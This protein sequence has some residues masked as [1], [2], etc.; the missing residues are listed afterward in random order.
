MRKKYRD[1]NI[2]NLETYNDIKNLVNF[3]NKNTLNETRVYI[4]III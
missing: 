3:K 4:C 1:I 2:E